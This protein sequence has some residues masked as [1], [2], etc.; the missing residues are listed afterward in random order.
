VV[1]FWGKAYRDLCN[2]HREIDER[3]VGRQE[4]IKWYRCKRRGKRKEK[5]RE[6]SKKEKREKRKNKNKTKGCRQKE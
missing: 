3:A 6:E 4:G 2:L 1:I 5:E